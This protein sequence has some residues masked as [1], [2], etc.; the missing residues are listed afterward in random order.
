MKDGTNE[1]TINRACLPPVLSTYLAVLEEEEYVMDDVTLGL[2]LPAPV[3]V[4]A[5]CTASSRTTLSKVD[6]MGVERRKLT[7]HPSKEL[8]TWKPHLSGVEKQE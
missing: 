5:T 4:P 1:E 6:S 2:A 7:L 8:R 3:R